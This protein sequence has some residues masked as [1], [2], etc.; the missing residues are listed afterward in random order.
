MSEEPKGLSPP[1]NLT[2]LWLL[3]LFLTFAEGAL[4]VGVAHTTGT[5]QT[6][7][8]TFSMALPVLVLLL[9]FLILWHK[10]YVLYGPRDFSDP[11]VQAYVTAMQSKPPASKTEERSATARPERLDG[12]TD[13]LPLDTIN[14]RTDAAEAGG[15]NTEKDGSAG[16]KLLES[17][18]YKEALP[19]IKE[20]IARDHPRHEQASMIAFT[21]YYALISGATEALTDLRRT[22][23]ENSK[24]PLARAWLGQ[25]LSHTGAH[26]EAVKQLEVALST[27]ED[28]SDRATIVR[29]LVQVLAKNSKNEEA[30][31]IIRTILPSITDP[32]S[33]A[34]LCN[35]GAKVYQQSTPP[36]H[37]KAFAL[38]EL[39]LSYTP[40]DQDLR[41]NLAYYYDKQNEPSL[42]LLHYQEL[43]AKDPDHAIATNNAGWEAKR[44]GLHIASVNYY[45]QS[46]SLGETLAMANLAFLLID[47]GFTKEAQE[48]LDRARAKE[49]PDRRVSRG[50]GEIANRQDEEDAKLREALEQ[51]RKARKWRRLQGEA[52]LTTLS[53]PSV[54]TGTYIDGSY[55]CIIQVNEKEIMEG[56]L[57]GVYGSKLT[58]KGRV[59][60]AVIE[61][62]WHQDSSLPSF[63]GSSSGNGLMFLSGD[64]LSGV[65]YPGS[66]LV[67][68]AKPTDLTEFF[69]R[70]IS[71]SAE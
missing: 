17:G 28:E 37:N 62:S 18:K 25:A 12:G 69:Y 64:Q 34:L 20:E 58:L 54:M 10:P 68:A 11:N 51:C 41:F 33:R 23:A 46:E 38:H 39:A 49:N 43:I 9:F 36:D 3:A 6:V 55:S 2:P 35:E 60:G 26:T 13:Q 14:E 61:F 16:W 22:V 65:R 21:Q 24:D 56:T 42:S 19:L 32:N 59:T 50:L 53:D 44:I 1:K 7:L 70:K 57:Q 48:I 67:N 52:L 31:Q 5:Q 29:F 30:L 45:R 71:N 4:G 47:A 8:L 27:A 15:L 40:S 63:I 66:Q